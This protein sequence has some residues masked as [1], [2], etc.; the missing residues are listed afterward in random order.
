MGQQNLTSVDPNQPAVRNA[1]YFFP[2]SLQL[3]PEEKT[4][5]FEVFKNTYADTLK[6]KVNL[7]TPAGNIAEHFPKTVKQTNDFLKPVNLSVRALTLF[8]APPTHNINQTTNIHVDSIK[9]NGNDTVLEARLSY[10]EMADTPG[11]IR[12]FPKDGEYTVAPYNFQPGKNESIIWVLPWIQ[13]LKE[14][15]YTWTDVPDWTFATSTNIPAAILRTNLP[16]HVIQGGGRRI[17]ISA[18]LVFA[19]SKQSTGVWDHIQQNYHL[20][21]I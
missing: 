14:G 8:I 6:N 3:D 15:Q 5:F 19:D 20:L 7:Y 2:L 17:T 11:V 21:G 9:I 1:E 10:Y 4:N 12:W 16:H 13:K 18:Q